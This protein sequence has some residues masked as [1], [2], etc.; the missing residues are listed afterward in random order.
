MDSYTNSQVSTGSSDTP[1]ETTAASADD[2]KFDHLLTTVQNGFLAV[3]V[4]LDY[5]VSTIGSLKARV[6]KE[7]ARI[8]ETETRISASEDSIHQ[9]THDKTLLKGEMTKLWAKCEDLESRLR[10]NNIRLVGLSESFF[11]GP[12]ESRI[13]DLLKSL[14]G[15]DSFSPQFLV[16]RAH[17]TLA[18]APKPGALPRTVIAKL[19]NYRDRDTALRFAR[20]MGPLRHGNDN[21]HIY[22]D[23]SAGV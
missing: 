3:N 19:L 8:T 20:E 1:E 5:I 14:L 22:P 11:K 15:E 21:I 9:N 23:F 7:S 10:R 18:S 2:I 4:K 6:N 12:M 17:R 13:E 16:E